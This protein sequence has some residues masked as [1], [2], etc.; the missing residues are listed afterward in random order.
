M[1]INKGYTKYRSLGICGNYMFR[2]WMKN[3]V[4]KD[5]FHKEYQN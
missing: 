1:E 2:I 5:K 3:F 4:V